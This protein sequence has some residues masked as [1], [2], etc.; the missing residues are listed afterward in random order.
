MNGLNGLDGRSVLIGGGLVLAGLFAARAGGLFPLMVI[1]GIVFF[2]GSKKGWW[3]DHG[4][5]AGP[6]NEL[7][8]RGPGGPPGF[9]AEWHRQAHANDAAGPAAHAAPPAPPA[10]PAWRPAQP[11]TPQPP[12]WQQAQP[13]QPAPAPQPPF[14]QPAAPYQQPTASAGYATQPQAPQ[15]APAAP[16]AAQDSEVR[17]P[18]TGAASTAPDAQATTGPETEYRRTVGEQD[19]PVAMA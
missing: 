5:H 2:V 10:P 19:G 9:F 12:A 4:R 15:P 11:P 7:A 14:Q 6:G 16:P 13:H 8:R 1:G 3:G 17:I 18:V